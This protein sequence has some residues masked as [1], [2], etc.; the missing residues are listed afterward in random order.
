[1]ASCRGEG[2][3]SEMTEEG[4]EQMWQLEAGVQ[5]GVAGFRRQG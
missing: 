1:M 4:G 5:N 2:R 3:D